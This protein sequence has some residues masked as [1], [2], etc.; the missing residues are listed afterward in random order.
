MPDAQVNPIKCPDGVMARLNELLRQKQEIDNRI[1][2]VV[3]T[4]A[5]CLNAPKDWILDT[6]IGAFRPKDGP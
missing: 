2:A 3:D 4:S 1:A 5:D 6:K